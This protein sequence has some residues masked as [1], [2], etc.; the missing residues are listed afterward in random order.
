MRS[1]KHHPLL[2]DREREVLRQVA[3]GRTNKEI[4]VCLNIV[5]TT[6][7]SHV[8]AILEKLGV[9][10]RTQA[11]TQAIQSALLSPDELQAA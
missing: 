10:S 3:L 5:E 7:K 11:A 9:Q 2:T 1:P 4:A 6:V 8:S